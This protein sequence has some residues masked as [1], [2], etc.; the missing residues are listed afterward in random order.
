MS[1]RG[2]SSLL[3]TP[4]PARRLCANSINAG[5]AWGW[6]ES[7][8]VA[9]VP[10]GSPSHRPTEGKRPPGTAPPP[11]CQVLG[12]H[13]AWLS[14]LRSGSPEE[15]RLSQSGLASD[16]D[17]ETVAQRGIATI[18]R[19]HSTYHGGPQPLTSK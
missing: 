14:P 11:G 5:G 4:L 16:L 13:S 12:A 1:Q 3:P 15:P 19:L 18:P 6:E 8:L 10:G 7:T 9:G 2:P 17:K